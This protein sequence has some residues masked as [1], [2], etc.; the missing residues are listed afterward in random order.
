MQ[1]DRGGPGE[2]KQM[3]RGGAD[4]GGW[5]DCGNRDGLTRMMK[6]RCVGGQEREEKKQK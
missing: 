6:N 1:V 3:K 2:E 4:G 5:R